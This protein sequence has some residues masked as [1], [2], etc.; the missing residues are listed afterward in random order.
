MYE[1]T[2]TYSVD[3]ASFTENGEITYTNI[4]DI[5]S[6]V[7]LINIFADEHRVYEIHSAFIWRKTRK[8]CKRE[9]P[10]DAF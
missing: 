1:V 2:I 9:V 3:Y 8:S 4:D 6:A 7:N 10:D 5:T